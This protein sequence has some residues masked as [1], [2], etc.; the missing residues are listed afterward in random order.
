MST[1][2]LHES[3]SGHPVTAQLGDE[4]LVELADIS[5][6]GYSWAVEP[7][8]DAAVSLRSINIIPPSARLIGG[9]GTCQISFE[10]HSPGKSELRLKLWRAWQGD[11]SITKRFTVPIEIRATGAP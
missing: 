2:H 11:A 6:T 5:T 8:P 7:I 1:V 9:H 4:I 3:D 10:I